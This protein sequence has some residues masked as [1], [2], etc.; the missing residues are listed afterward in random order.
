MG[1]T[2]AIFISLNVHKMLYSIPVTTVIFF[3]SKEKAF[4]M[5]EPQTGFDQ[6]H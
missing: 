5:K 6:D 3:F 1:C 4:S 2:V